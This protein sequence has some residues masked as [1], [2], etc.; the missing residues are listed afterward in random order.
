MAAGRSGKK[1]AKSAMLL[2]SESVPS[3]AT[4]AIGMRSDEA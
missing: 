4:N 2:Q 1:L 3:R